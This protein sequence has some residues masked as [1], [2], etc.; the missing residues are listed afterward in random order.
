MV[1]TGVLTPVVRAGQE[2]RIELGLVF[3]ECRLS[4]IRQ[5]LNKSTPPTLPEQRVDDEHIIEQRKAEAFLQTVRHG[6]V[7]R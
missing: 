3:G 7:R 2:I 6:A 5:R 1:A 4:S